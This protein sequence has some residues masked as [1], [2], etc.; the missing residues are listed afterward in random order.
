MN[1]KVIVIGLDGGSWNYIQKWIDEGKLPAFK[2]LQDNGVWGVLESQLPPVTSPNWKCFSTGLN[3]AKLGVFWWENID[4]KNRKIYIPNA[5]SFKGKEIFD[6]LSEAGK[7]VGVI[8]MPTLYPPHQINGVMVAGGPDAMESGFAYS[9]ALEKM[10]KSKFG[11]RVLPSNIS[12]MKKDAAEVIEEI[13]QLIEARFKAAEFLLSEGN[14]DFFMVAVYLINVLQHYHWGDDKVFKAWQ[15]IDRGIG[16]L[17]ERFSDYTFL[18]MSD[19]GTNEIKIKFN[20]SAWLVEKGYLKLKSD[21]VSGKLGRWGISRQKVTK[22]L[23]KLGL[24]EFVKKVVP[25]NLQQLLPDDVGH[26][27]FAGK[28]EIIDWEKSQAIASGQGP[29][30]LLN[31]EEG[32]KNQ[33]IKELESLE[34][35][36]MKIVR[37][38]Y[39]KEEIYKG[40]YFD[41]A[42]DL[43]VDQ[44]K[45]THFSGA[46]GSKEVFE[47]PDT[48]KGE[49]EKFGLF[50]AFG[51]GIKPQKLDTSILNLA[52]TILSMM[53]VSISKEMDGEVIRL[54]D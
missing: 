41:E 43:I 36:G 26:V 22:I 51:E 12:F 50:L 20:I 30:Y 35:Q 53:G 11:W 8:N 21:S 44:A 47:A 45:N 33:L 27:N 17:L 49:N 25:K 7:R 31:K 28:A 6:Y 3:P 32:F 42:P 14:F 1:R 13:Y 9:E 34:H 29:I 48:W 46:I 52:P 38:V 4:I 5:Q 19:H 23:T 16:I 24:K 10:L 2:K 39:K 37:H 40:P 18:F 54:F 15:I